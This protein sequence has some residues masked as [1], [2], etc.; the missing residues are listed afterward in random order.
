MAF[1]EW[2]DVHIDLDEEA[3]K[4]GAA[5][6]G[7]KAG[8]PEKQA[9]DAPAPSEKKPTAKKPTGEGSAA[10]PEKKRAKK[11][12]AEKGADKPAEE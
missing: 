5:K 3:P 9:K 7:R 6:S 11:P 1:I 2:V 4:P 8:K 10:A 12:R